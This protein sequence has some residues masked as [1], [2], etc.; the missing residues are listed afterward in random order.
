MNDPRL[1]DLINEMTA[2]SDEM[3]LIPRYGKRDIEIK[4]NTISRMLISW[5]RT[6]QEALMTHQKGKPK[7][8][9]EKAEKVIVLRHDGK[10]IRAISKIVGISTTTVQKILRESATAHEEKAITNRCPRPVDVK[11]TEEQERALDA[12]KKGDNV[13]LTGGAGTGKSFVV[14]KFIA[15]AEK[16]QKD[17]LVAAP[18]G[19]AA[20]NI[21]GCTL[22][23]AFRIKIGIVERFHGKVSAECKRILNASSILVIDEISMCRYDLFSFVMDLI[24]HE[25]GNGHHIQVIVSGD[26]CQLPPVLTPKDKKLF[27]KLYPCCSEN[28]WAFE[29]PEWKS[30]QFRTYYLTR[31]IRQGN[32]DFIAALNKIRVGDQD[33]TGIDFINAHHVKSK[34]D[35]AIKVCS[36]NNTAKGINDDMLRQLSGDSKTFRLKKCGNVTKDDITLEMEIT[37]KPGARV[38]ILANDPDANRY[39]NGTFATVLSLSDQGACVETDDHKKVMIMNRE[40]D[41]FGYK[42]LKDKL[43][44]TRIGTYTQI[45]LK[46]GWAITIHK[47]QGQT[48]TA[49]NLMLDNLWAPGQMYVALSRLTSISSMYLYNDIKKNNLHTSKEVLRFYDELSAS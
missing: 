34:I 14:N 5:S 25:A 17:I 45:P 48:Y 10:S 44:R 12:M 22:H 35:N 11:L 42:I 18:T 4:C 29:T 24:Q 8:A 41:V 36:T 33:H 20:K 27:K 28:A 2:V 1:H 31:I 15:W 16:N 46:L 32:P 49:A 23:R 40:F 43:I 9:P 26:F 7:T 39:Q 38:I 21:D 30:C 19:I 37:L 47:S 6:F 13:F 3:R